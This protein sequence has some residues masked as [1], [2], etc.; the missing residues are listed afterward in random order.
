MRTERSVAGAELRYERLRA[1]MLDVARQCGRGDLPALTGLLEIEDAL[2]AARGL[3]LHLDPAAPESLV[4]VLR[5][6]PRDRALTLAVGPEGGFA[7]D[8]VAQL[9]AA[10]F[11]AVRLAPFVLRTEL[12][13]VAAL[14]VVAAH[15]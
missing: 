12:A 9:A 10:G 3:L 4:E 5:S 8:E 13:A 2:R 1:V 15:E 7:S 14:S 6:A 11:V